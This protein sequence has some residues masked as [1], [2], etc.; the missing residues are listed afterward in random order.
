MHLSTL[1]R[2][3]SFKEYYC[4]DHLFG[5]MKQGLDGVLPSNYVERERISRLLP[6]FKY[7]ENLL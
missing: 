2:N 6:L 7:E 4:S 3:F 1:E 5:P